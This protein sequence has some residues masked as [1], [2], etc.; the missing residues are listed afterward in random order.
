MA[1][2]TRSSISDGKTIAIVAVVSLILVILLMIWLARRLYSSK[3]KQ[4]ERYEQVKD[5]P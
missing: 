5:E 1:L 4:H 3:K 2:K